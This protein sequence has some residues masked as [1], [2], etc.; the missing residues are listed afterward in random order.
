MNIA[1]FGGTGFIGSRIARELVD[2]G[3]T[4][5]LLVRPGSERKLTNSAGC[6]VVYG[7]IESDE[8]IRESLTNAEAAIYAIGIIREFPRRGIT[9]ENLHYQSIV[10]MVNHAQSIGVKRFLLISAHGAAA[11]GTAYQTTKFRAE[12]HLKDS[13]LAW[14]IFRPSIVFGDPQGGVEFCTMLRDK[15]IE[16][17]FPA[18]LF[19]KGADIA[20]AGT[21]RFSPVHVG[22]VAKAVVRSLDF[23]SAVNTVYDLGGPVVIDWKTLIA[24]IAGACG[25]KKASLPAPAAAVSL[26]AAL[27]ERFSWFP[28]TRDQIAM[29]LEGNV[30]D[31]SRAFADFGIDPTPFDAAHLGYLKKHGKPR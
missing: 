13:G 23:P 28:V 27:F 14:T 21:F 18:P 31:G 11:K 29:L 4:P 16:S 2:N 12:E 1:L 26:A 8:A 5:I 19:F 7:D 20:R 15:I 6:T 30:C 24:T 3:H 10:R 9:Y 22:D 17:P 25:R